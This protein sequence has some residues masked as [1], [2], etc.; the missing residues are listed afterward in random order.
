M[1]THMHLSAANSRATLFSAA[2]LATTQAFA[3]E[4]P[5]TG[6]YGNDRGCELF[7]KGGDSAVYT[8]GAT[9][10]NDDP[11]YNPQIDAEPVIVTSK[12]IVSYEVGCVPLNN[13]FGKIVC[14]PDDMNG[15]M[16][17]HLTLDAATDTLLLGEEN[18]EPLHRCP[19]DENATM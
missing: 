6:I 1:A 9:I 10:E 13:G 19:T 5:I 16:T 3:R 8:D 14:E 15:E 12:A 18:P 2:L 7:A 4:L 11:S 17:L